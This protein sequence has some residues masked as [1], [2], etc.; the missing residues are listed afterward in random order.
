MKNVNWGGVTEYESG[1]KF[2]KFK[3]AAYFSVLNF[4]WVQIFIHLKKNSTAIYIAILNFKNLA[5][6]S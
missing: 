3:M 1:I 2:P 4:Y 5:L 6:D